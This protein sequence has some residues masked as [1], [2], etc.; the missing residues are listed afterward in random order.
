MDLVIRSF[1]FERQP[2]IYNFDP[3]SIVPDPRPR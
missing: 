3:V 1:C 2:R